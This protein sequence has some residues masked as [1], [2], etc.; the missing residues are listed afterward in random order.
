MRETSKE[1]TAL[2]RALARGLEEDRS[3]DVELAGE[4]IEVPAYA[5]IRVQYHVR[6]E[7]QIS[8][9][10]IWDRV[11]EAPELIRRHDDQVQDEAGQVYDV[12]IYGERVG[13][14]WEG[15]IDFVPLS[16]ALPSKRTGRET[17]QP[18]R[19]ALE[20]WATGLEPLYLAGAF[21]RAT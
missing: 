1:V 10:V 5:D 15:W 21:E 11:A 6:D 18:D 7:K 14:K 4:Q 13:G 9:D 3:V 17:T 12:L 19:A 20:Y 16:A 8:I 2:L